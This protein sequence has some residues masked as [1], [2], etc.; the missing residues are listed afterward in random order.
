VSEVQARWIESTVAST[1][2]SSRILL[3]TDPF[4][5]SI[6]MSFLTMLGELDCRAPVSIAVGDSKRDSSN[7]FALKSIARCFPGSSAPGQAPR[8]LASFDRIAC[9]MP[10]AELRTVAQDWYEPERWNV[11]EFVGVSA[12]RKLS[13]FPPRLR[14]DSQEVRYALLTRK[15]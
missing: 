1:G 7:P 3:V 5:N 15:P 11:R 10:E 14:L 9:T 12:K 2:A 8:D 6:N 13:L 4:N